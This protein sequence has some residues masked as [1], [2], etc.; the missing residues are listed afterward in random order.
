MT[1]VTTPF[2]DTAIVV[3]DQPRHF[4]WG[5]VFAGAV[6]ATAVTFLFI[7]LGSGIGLA[8]VSSSHAPS[9]D[10]TF[11][12]LGAIYFFASQAFGFTIGGYLV[13]RLI[14]P[15][16]ETSE[17]EEFRAAAHGFVMWGLVVVAGLVIA[18]IVPGYSF[19]MADTARMHDISDKTA[20]IITLWTAFALLFGAIVATAAAI[21]SRWMD[22]K[23]SF[24]MAPRI[25]RR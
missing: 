24:S 8:L 16:I 21:S 11:L 7:T 12:N 5:A 15:E 9:S 2:N 22:D 4:N 19:S 17:E 23:I 18:S 20:S 1:G 10:L 6:G 13:G 25:R 3:A 14:G